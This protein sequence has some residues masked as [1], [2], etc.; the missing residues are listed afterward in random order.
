MLTIHSSRV[1]FLGF[2]FWCAE[3]QR[4]KRV[5][6][7]EGMRCSAS[8]KTPLWR[9]GRRRAT[10]LCFL[11]ARASSS[12]LA[13]Q[14]LCWWRIGQNALN[15]LWM[16]FCAWGVEEVCCFITLFLMGDSWRMQMSKK[17]MKHGSI[18]RMK[19]SR[20]SFFITRFLKELSGTHMRLKPFNALLVPQWQRQQ[21][22]AILYIWEA[23]NSFFLFNIKLF[24]C[25]W[26][27]LPWQW[28][29]QR[30]ELWRCS[31]WWTVKME[32]WLAIP[33]RL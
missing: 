16:A 2:A 23:Y 4:R 32:V 30:W 10:P 17:S 18:G 28:Q 1:C 25:W 8:E 12:L 9:S 7:K 13:E 14:A 22:P 24:D 5:T 3:A 31:K 11:A 21:Q 6:R 27:C 33:M 26:Q 19:V 29:D 20:S 15:A